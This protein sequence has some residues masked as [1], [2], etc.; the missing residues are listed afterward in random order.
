MRSVIIKIPQNNINEKDNSWSRRTEPSAT[1][2]Q[3]EAMPFGT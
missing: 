1:G 2:E 3:G